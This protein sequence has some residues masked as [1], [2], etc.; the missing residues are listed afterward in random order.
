MRGDIT[1]TINGQ[2]FRATGAFTAPVAPPSIAP[3]EP[4]HLTM[5]VDRRKIKRAIRKIVEALSSKPATEPK[6]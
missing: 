5:R 3:L 1:V 2:T 4:I 6:P